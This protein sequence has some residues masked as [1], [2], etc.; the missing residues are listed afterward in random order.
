[1]KRHEI[2]VLRRAGFSLR[3][4]ARKAGIARNTVKRILEETQPI[5]AR[6]RP[7]GRP[8]IAT[9]F[10]VLVEQI[11]RERCDLPTVEILRR[12]REQGYAGGKNPVYQMV[13]RL[14]KIVTPPLV[15]FEG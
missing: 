7:V 8:S 12:L 11:L 4:V 2:E 1:M 13:R 14:R 15:R 3:A 9:P 10:E 5:E 6:R